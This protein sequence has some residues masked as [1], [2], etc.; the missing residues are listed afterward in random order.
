MKSK[1]GRNKGVAIEHV[2]CTSI[3]I[4][5]SLISRMKEKQRRE[6]ELGEWQLDT[7]YATEPDWHIRLG[8]QQLCFGPVCIAQIHVA[9]LYCPLLCS[10]AMTL[11]GQSHLRNP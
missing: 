3:Q 5:R 4:Q 6:G 1:G 8:R 10:L 7:P 11:V 2:S 9:V